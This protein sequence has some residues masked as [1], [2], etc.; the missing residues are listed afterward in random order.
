MGL[1]GVWWGI[2]GGCG[3]G[4]RA[5]ELTWSCRNWRDSTLPGPFG[6]RHKALRTI[7]CRLKPHSDNFWGP[8]HCPLQEFQWI[9]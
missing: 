1:D 3:S 4:G 8:H 5:S 6:A 7:Q 9:L 2:G